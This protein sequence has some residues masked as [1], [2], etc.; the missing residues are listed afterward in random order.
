MNQHGEG[1]PRRQRGEGDTGRAI[2][3][4]LSLVGPLIIIV[5]AKPLCQR[6]HCLFVVRR[7]DLQAFLRVRAIVALNYIRYANDKNGCVRY[8]AWSG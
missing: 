1:R 8:A 2:T 4:T 6:A 5:L 7:K 3:T